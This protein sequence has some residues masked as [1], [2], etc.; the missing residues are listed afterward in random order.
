MFLLLLAEVHLQINCRC[1]YESWQAGRLL[2]EG[3][4][5]V[6]SGTRSPANVHRRPQ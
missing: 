2:V 3:C 5:D 1:A 4:N 6:W